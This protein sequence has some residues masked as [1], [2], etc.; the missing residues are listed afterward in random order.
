[1][2][3]YFDLINR[4]KLGLN[5]LNN[6]LDERKGCLPYFVT[7]FK[8]DPAE[9][10]HD[11]P[12]FGDLTSRYIEAFIKA[13][14]MIPD[15]EYSKTE[16]GLRKLFNSY[17]S[18]GDG[19]SYR[20]KPE[21]P[22]YSTIF[23]RD[24]DAHVAEGFD[25]ARVLWALLA[26]YEESNDSQ[27]YTR[28][29]ELVNG[30]DRILIKKEDYGY[31]D[32]STIIPGIVIDPDA[33]PMPH[34]YYFCGTQIHPLIEAYRKLK[35][36]KALDIALRLT[37]YIV[38]HSDYFLTDG[39]WNCT[40]GAGFESAEIDGH[41][42]SRFAVIAGITTVGVVTGKKDLIV[43]MKRA[44]DWFIQ[45]H[46]SSFGWSPEF[47]G[48]FGDENEGCETCT[49][50][51]QINCCFAFTE[52]GYI[53]Y[54]KAAERVCRN[55]LFENQ[56]LDTHLVRNSIEKPD[57]ELS[58]FHNVASMVRGGFAGWAAPNDFIGNCDHHYCLMNC[59]G[60][61]GIRAIHDVW[62]N[63]Y[64]VRGTD[65]FV[66]IYMDRTGHELIIKNHQPQNDTI[67]ITVKSQCNLHLAVRS[68]FNP[69]ISITVNGKNQKF[70][71]ASDYLKINRVSAASKVILTTQL[72]N[73][74]ETCHVNGRNYE[75]TWKG[76]TVIAI[77]PPGKYMPFY[78]NRRS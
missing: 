42:H 18:E 28:I 7:I 71:V 68:W 51:D 20:P 75:V 39:S 21:K 72:E 41:T 9:A 44:Y 26:W 37:N 32:R 30:L 48:R 15:L 65:V 64:T 8:R 60:P 63:I 6:N 35:I 70:V 3:N 43:V 74:P 66:N 14:E 49:I 62:N 1:M 58:C 4:V 77:D 22:Y 56:M 57:T 16:L 59:C 36:E 10:R 76:D 11:W 13:R 38:Y 53:E 40:K 2:E 55:Q 73:I 19:L 78:T 5:F 23:K 29:V 31:Y 24:Y 25:Q 52:A 45:N 69:K 27:V 47:L 34:Q 61:A 17:F 12:D 50:M 33:A 67:E 54:Y 46:C